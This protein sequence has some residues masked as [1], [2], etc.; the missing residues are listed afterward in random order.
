MWW[1]AAVLWPLGVLFLMAQNRGRA[2]VVV[3]G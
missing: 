3:M 1:I 2:P